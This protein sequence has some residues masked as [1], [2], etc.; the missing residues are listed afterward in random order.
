MIQ[1]EQ[2]KLT[3]PKFYACENP[4]TPY[5]IKRATFRIKC[6]CDGCYKTSLI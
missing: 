2:I 1:N 6:Y 3:I 5:K 4:P